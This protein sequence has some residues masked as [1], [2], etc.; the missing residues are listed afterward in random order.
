M[1]KFITVVLCLALTVSALFVFASCGG[2]Q[3]KANTETSVEQAQKSGTDNEETSEEPMSMVN[4]LVEYDTLEEAEKASGLNLSIPDKITPVKFIV[5][6]KS[7]LE[8]TYDGGYIR[9]A[10][11]GGDISGDYN[12]YNYS[13]AALL[14][15]K[16]VTYK[17]DS[18]NEIKLAIWAEGE[19]SFCFYSETPV[20]PG[21]MNS[22]IN[23][24]G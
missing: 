5:I 18:Q 1:K 10:R 16:A 6:D 22:Y 24:T 17:G 2:T 19:N 20:T 23:A 15:E 3:T 8:V 11:W 14:G 9:K 4:P 21:T 13:E 7:T 12:N